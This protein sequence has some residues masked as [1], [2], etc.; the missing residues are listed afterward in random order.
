MYYIH[1]SPH[2]DSNTRM[3]M[4]V[5]VCVR[6]AMSHRRRFLSNTH[7]RETH[8]RQASDV[9][10]V[11]E[12]A[13]WVRIGPQP[14]TEGAL[15]YASHCCLFVSFT[16]LW[17]LLIHLSA[18][19]IKKSSHAQTDAR[20]WNSRRHQIEIFFRFMDPRCSNVHKAR[21]IEGSFYGESLIS[22]IRKV[23]CIKKKQICSIFKMKI[24]IFYEKSGLPT[25][26]CNLECFLPDFKNINKRI[27]KDL[28]LFHHWIKTHIKYLRFIYLWSLQFR[29]KI[30]IF[31]KAAWIYRF[32]MK[33]NKLPSKAT[34]KRHLRLTG[35]S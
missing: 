35:S 18:L 9:T 26:E 11:I 1:E 22:L 2:R 27:N 31:C 10:V 17:L 16:F 23:L 34:Q 4:C 32:Q 15:V 24:G 25:F 20:R 21:G 7:T 33:S 28:R 8:G 6:A 3:R 12:T 29:L 5:S 14:L 30:F 19:L 13:G